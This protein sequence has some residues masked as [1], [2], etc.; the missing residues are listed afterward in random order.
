MFNF[1]PDRA[2][3]IV[4]ALTLPEFEGFQRVHRPSLDVA[5]FTQYETDLPVSVVFPPE[6]LD[7][8]LGQVVAEHEGDLPRALRR[9]GHSRREG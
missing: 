3:Q 1:R 7:Q 2:R 6:S 5:T 4:Q 8:L 9:R